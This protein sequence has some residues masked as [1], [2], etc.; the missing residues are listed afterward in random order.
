MEGVIILK[1]YEVISSGEGVLIFFIAAALTCF[2]IGIL[3]LIG[4]IHGWGTSIICGFVCL[5]MFFISIGNKE[6][7]PQYEAYVDTSIVDMEKFANTY[8]IIDVEDNIWTIQDK[9]IK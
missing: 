4:D 7:V 3:C 6:T 9:E 8:E 5:V 1:T 2:L